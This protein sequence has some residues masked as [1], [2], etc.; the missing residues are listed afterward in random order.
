MARFSGIVLC[1]RHRH[2]RGRRLYGPITKSSSTSEAIM[3]GYQTTRELNAARAKYRGQIIPKAALTV[4]DAETSRLT[5]SDLA[6]HALT[7]GN[8]SPDFILPDVHGEP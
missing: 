2:R 4:M 8:I 5:A 7:V 6:A 1:H 3:I